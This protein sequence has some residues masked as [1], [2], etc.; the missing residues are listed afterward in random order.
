MPMLKPLDSS[1]EMENTMSD[2]VVNFP[3]KPAI[4]NAKTRKRL[5]EGLKEHSDKPA[6]VVSEVEKILCTQLVTVVRSLARQAGE[7]LAGKVMKTADHVIRKANE[8]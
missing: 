2:N 5:E 3:E 7:W 8:R 1:G 4:F 6:K